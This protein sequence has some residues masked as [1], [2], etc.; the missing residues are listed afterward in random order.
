MRNILMTIAFDGTEYCGFQVQ[1]NG[2][3]IAKKIQDAIETV[4]G[5]RS[6]IKGCSRTDAGVHAKKF[7][8]SFFTDSTLSDRNLQKALDANLPK[9]IAAVSC[10]TVDDDFHARYSCRGK[11]YR[12]R[13]WNGESKNPFD[14][15]A[16]WYKKPLDVEKMREA[17]ERIVGKKD[18]KAFMASG[19]NITDT[20]RTVFECNVEKYDEYVEITVSA[21]GFLYNMVR[22]IVGT[23]IAVS[24]GKILPRDID[25]IIEKGDRADAGVTVP[26]CGLF[27]NEVY[28]D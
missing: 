26:A 3:S 25:K 5:E 22:I 8:V 27:L 9:D 19:S 4:T 6:D 12:Y 2:V 13:I 20:V 24:E 23:L 14:K 10:V 18:F 28:Y 11:K 15:R 1:K 17:A 7:C 21:D 16:M